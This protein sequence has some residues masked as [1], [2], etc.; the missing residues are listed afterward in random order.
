MADRPS[1]LE[2]TM[3]SSHGNLRRVD[4]WFSGRPDAFGE[5]FPPV[6][7]ELTKLA[8]VEPD[9]QVTRLRIHLWVSS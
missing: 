6:F 7:G 8:T 4:R 5:F 1:D 3:A 2:K 9:P